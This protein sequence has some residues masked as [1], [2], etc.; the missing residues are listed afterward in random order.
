VPY[1]TAFFGTAFFDKPG[2][3]IS[4]AVPNGI[5]TEHDDTISVL[6]EEETPSMMA[7]NAFVA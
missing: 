6:T 5:G 3:E 7:T 2:L 4:G 1:K